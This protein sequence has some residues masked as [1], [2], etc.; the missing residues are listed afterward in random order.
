MKLT[1]ESVTEVLTHCLFTVEELPEGSEPPEDTVFVEGIMNPWGFHPGRLNE[2]KDTIQSLLEQLPLDFREESRGG[3]GGRS[4]LQACI[5]KDGDQ[6]GEHIHM[7][8]LFSLGVGVGL[9]KCLMPPAHVASATGRNAVLLDLCRRPGGGGVIEVFKDRRP[10]RQITIRGYFRQVAWSIWHRIELRLNR[11]RVVTKDSS[12]CA[13][14]SSPASGSILA[15]THLHLGYLIQPYLAHRPGCE[16]RFFPVEPCS[17]CNGTGEG[18]D[19]NIGGDGF[20]DYDAPTV[21]G[22]CDGV[23]R[24]GFAATVAAC[25]A[26]IERLEGVGVAS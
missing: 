14:E 6:W 12:G 16:W 13:E 25:R 18:P 9:A 2:S 23:D 8:Q 17:G 10:L 11:A 15:T 20:G 1:A 19:V 3:G 4:F 21:C 22:E 26:K 24:T 5:T 7:D